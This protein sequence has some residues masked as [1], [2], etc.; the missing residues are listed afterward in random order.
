MGCNHLVRAGGL[1]GRV[2]AAGVNRAAGRGPVDAGRDLVALTRMPIA[3]NCCWSPPPTVTF[4]GR[5]RPRPGLTATGPR[6]RRMCRADSEGCP[7]PSDH[8]EG[9]GPARGIAAVPRDGAAGGSPLDG[10]DL[11]R[12]G[13]ES[14]RRL[15]R[16][17]QLHPSK[18]NSA[19]AIRAYRPAGT[20]RPRSHR[21]SVPGSIPRRRA[22]TSWDRPRS[23]LKASRRLPSDP[24]VFQGAYPRNATIAGRNQSAGVVRLSSQFVTEQ[25]S[26]PSR[27]ATSRWR[28]PRSSRRFRR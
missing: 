11:A 7:A 16:W 26:A 20:R 17:T 23:R 3:V 22:Q 27:S 4:D 13:D 25:V 24:S 28:S 19:S 5:P 21:P 18:P 9:H 2:H 1:A 10:G 14:V 12:A 6:S 8:L 15:I